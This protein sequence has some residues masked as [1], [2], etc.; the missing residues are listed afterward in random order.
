MGTATEMRITTMA[1]TII[2]SI[3]VKPFLRRGDRGTGR[4]GDTKPDDVSLFSPSP[5]LPVSPSMLVLP[6]RITSP[7]RRLLQGLA[8]YIKHVLPAPAHRLGIVLRAANPPV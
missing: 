2:S 8:V 3:M 7:V 1:M 6:V 4:R 5:R